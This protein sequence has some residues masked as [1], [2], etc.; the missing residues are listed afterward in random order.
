MEKDTLKQWASNHE[1]SDEIAEAIH[2]ISSGSRSVE[3]IWDDPT[4][5]E[6]A[7]VVEIAFENT[8]YNGLF[9]GTSTV[10]R[11]EHREQ[12]NE[13]ELDKFAAAM[14]EMTNRNWRS[15]APSYFEPILRGS[16]LWFEDNATLEEIAADG[17]SLGSQETARRILRLRA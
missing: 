4:D 13:K 16:P 10:K 8:K 11:P 7:R 17:S 6:Y 3:A 9:W 14:E 12:D 15:G 1:T 2:E 5:T